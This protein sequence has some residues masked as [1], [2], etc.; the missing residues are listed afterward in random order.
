[1]FDLLA[2]GGYCLSLLPENKDIDK[3]GRGVGSVVSGPL[4]DALLGSQPWVEE[5]KMGYGTAYGG[6]I[7]FTGTSASLGWFSWIDMRTG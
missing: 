7:V 6:Q 4:S 5:T 1:M 2:A 3:T